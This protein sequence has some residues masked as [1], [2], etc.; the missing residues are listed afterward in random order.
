MEREIVVERHE[1][2]GLA[3]VEIWLNRPEKG[4]AL[5]RPMLAQL[6]VI[7]DDLRADHEV[8]AVVL[9]GRG[10]FFCT[11]GDIAAWGGLTPHEMGRD[12]ILAGIDVFE[13]IAALPQPV[14]AAVSGHALGGG[15]ELAMMA[16]LRLALASARL[17]CPEVT[18]GMIPGWTGTRRL[19]ELIGPARAR[20]IVL[21][22]AP[23]TAA[24]AETWGLVTAVAETPET[25]EATL[26][27]WLDRLL[28]N[29]PAAMALA[30]GLLA[31][32]H[33]DARHHHASAAGQA[34]GTDE[35]REGVTAFREKR[36]PIFGKR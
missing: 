28:K 23:V 35:C 21:L 13:R 12:W 16:D 24:Q 31:T 29:G 10:R 25:F 26:D 34:A 2:Q 22:G 33:A 30:K 8:R 32:V 5:T 15:L 14:I 3:W 20:H 1:R 11:G 36:P 19:A 9:R 7:A 6:G 4:N 18:I 17:G 27:G